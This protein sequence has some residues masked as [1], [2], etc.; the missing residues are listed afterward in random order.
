MNPLFVL[1]LA[2]VA[3][4][5]TDL[6]SEE[7]NLD[8][9]PCKSCTNTMNLVKRILQNSVVETHIRFLVKYLCKG[10]DSAK[11]A[12]EK[13]IQHEVDGAVGYLIQHN[14]TDICHVIRLC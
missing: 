8:F 5:G 2:A 6:A 10:A 14:A 1:V 13:F 9:N 4:A 3:F 11:D 12:C 7:P